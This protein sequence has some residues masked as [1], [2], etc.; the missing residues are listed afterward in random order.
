MH[1]QRVR[2]G[3]DLDLPVRLSP[4]LDRTCRIYKCGE[5]AI[6]RALCSSHYNRERSATGQPRQFAKVGDV[7]VYDDGYRKVKTE[8]GWQAEHRI[9]MER[10]L[11]RSLLA[12][13]TVHHINGDRLD[14]RIENLELWVKSQ[15][16]GQRVIDKLEWAYAFIEQYRDVQGKLL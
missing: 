9:V 16:A 11:G 6:A 15:P 2:T 7:R 4:R 1:Y 10:H 5:K 13:E 8:T 14:N 12:G 3:R